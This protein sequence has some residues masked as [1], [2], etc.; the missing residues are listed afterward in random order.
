MEEE[1]QEGI[2]LGEVLSVIWKRIVWILAVSVAAAL[3]CGLLVQFVFG[4]SKEKYQISFVLEYPNQY[5]LDKDGNATEKM[6][7]PDGTTFRIETAFYAENLKAVKESNEAFSNLKLD[8]IALSLGIAQAEATSGKY[9]VT[10]DGKYFKDAEQATDFMQA[11]CGQM[12]ASIVERAVGTNFSADLSRYELVATYARQ[13]EILENQRAY[14]LGQYDKYLALHKNFSY[15]GKQIETYRAELSEIFN[16]RVSL[17]DGSVVTLATVKKDLQNNRYLYKETASDIETAIKAFELKKEV[18]DEARAALEEK[19]NDYKAGNESAEQNNSEAL[20][21]YHNKISAYIDRNAQIDVEI[22]ALRKSIDEANVEGDVS[23]F[24]EKLEQ[25]Y[26]AV[27][28]ETQTCKAV[29][30]AFCEEYT[31]I[32]YEQS[33]AVTVGGM[34]MLKYAVI[35]FILAF[36][37]ASV[38]ICVIHFIRKKKGDAKA[39]ETGPAEAVETEE[40]LA[41]AAVAKEEKPK[42]E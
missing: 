27:A 36:I 30:T 12:K 21:A 35:A 16:G 13:I 10:V 32:D 9:T 19:V 25:L 42:K 22:R 31:V 7:Y 24:R 8:K 17:E 23:A 37:V 28:A 3:V 11:V 34:S 20:A 29:V 40:I 1:R 39:E 41:E 14:L 33:G 15:E 5:A 18:N 4:P 26:K 6:V 2:S 38:V